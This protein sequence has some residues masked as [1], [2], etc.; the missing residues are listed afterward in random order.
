MDNE[1]LPSKECMARCG[2][3]DLKS[4]SNFYTWNNKQEGAAR[5]FS[6]LDRVL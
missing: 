4:T 6:K 3:E 1:M 5:V 2:I